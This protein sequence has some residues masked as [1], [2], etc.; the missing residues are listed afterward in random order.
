MTFKKSISFGTAEELHR[1]REEEF[2]ALSPP[3]RMEHFFLMILESAMMFGV[4]PKKKGN[5][6]IYYK[7][8]P[9][10]RQKH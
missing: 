10:L 5:F 2:L 9:R 4:K 1:K 3:E 8:D 6:E 7:D